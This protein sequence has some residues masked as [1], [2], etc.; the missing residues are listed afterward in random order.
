MSDAP[1]SWRIQAETDRPHIARAR[2][3]R[4]QTLAE[5]DRLAG[6]IVE[7]AEQT[8]HGRLLTGWRVRC[9]ILDMR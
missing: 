9:R 5:Y 2:Q 1:L 7:W 6:L 4:P 8:P 3:A